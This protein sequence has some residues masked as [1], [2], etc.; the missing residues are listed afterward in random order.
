[1]T[2]RRGHLFFCIV[3]LGCGILGSYLGAN[4]RSAAYQSLGG[5][6]LDFV[7]K[8]LIALGEQ[9]QR[10]RQKAMSAGFDNMALAQSDRHR[11]TEWLQL[12][13]GR[14]LGLSEVGPDAVNAQFL[15]IQHSGD[16][17]LQA[18]MARQMRELVANDEFPK[19]AYATFIDRQLV[20]DGHPQRYGTQADESFELYP[21]E[22]HS[23][24]DARRE[25]MGL[26]PIAELKSTLE[27]VKQAIAAGKGIGE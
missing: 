17:V 5:M 9:D 16:R 3:A 7:S 13:S 14:L 23:R 15:F 24:V 19:D 22:D 10:D 6:D 2:F 20:Y 25:S 12:T 21:I 1:M 27:Q 4:F 26:P 18:S 8:Q 11:E